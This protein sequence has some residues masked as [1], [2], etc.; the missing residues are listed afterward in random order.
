M[1]KSKSL[2]LIGGSKGNAH[3]RN[4]HHLVADYFHEVLIVTN[5]EIDYEAF[6]VLNFGLKKKFN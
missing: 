4:Y 5:Q 2:L 1:L 6:R 3:L